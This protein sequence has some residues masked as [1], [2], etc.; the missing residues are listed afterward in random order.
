MANAA[1]IHC[2]SLRRYTQ[3]D[4]GVRKGIIEKSCPNCAH[5]ETILLK[6]ACPRRYPQANTI[7]SNLFYQHRSL[8]TFLLDS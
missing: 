5:M 8:K 6:L 3:L 1:L 7:G 2:E 4:I